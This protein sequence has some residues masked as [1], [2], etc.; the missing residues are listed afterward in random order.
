VLFGAVILVLAVFVVIKW[1]IRRDPLGGT[2]IGIAMIVYGL[3]FGFF[4]TDGRVLL[5]YWGVSQ[6]RYTTYDLLVLVG[7][8]LTALSQ[9]PSREPSERIDRRAI[10][11]IALGVM[12]VQLAFSVHYGIAGARS[13]HQ[14][15]VSTVT[16]MRNIEHESDLTVYSLDIGESPQ[17]IKEDEAF[18]REHHLSLYG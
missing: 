8:Y 2:P 7:I 15:E 9:A 16:L 5:G 1:G 17:E 3:L 12:A 11:G 6:S 18:L 14:A 10:A 4:I 13:E